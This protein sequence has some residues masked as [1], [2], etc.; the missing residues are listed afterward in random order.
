MKRLEDLLQSV[1]EIGAG[2]PSVDRTAASWIAAADGDSPICPRCGGFGFL[3]RDLPFGHPDFGRAVP[4]A[5][6]LKET[7]AEREHRLRRYSNLGALSRYTFENLAPRGHGASPAQQDRYERVVAAVRRFAEQPEGWL[8]LTGPSGSGKTHLAAALGNRVI[9]AGKSAL[10]MVVPDL[11]D[12]LR[13]SFAPNSEVPY[14]RL[15]DQVRNAG[16][17][18]LDDLGSQSATPWAV[19]KLYQIINHRF[20]L[21]LPTVLT[22]GTTIDE[23]D[24]RLRSRLAD[25]ALSNVFLLEMGPDEAADRDDPLTL[26]LLREMTFATFNYRATGPDLPDSVARKLQQ[27]F[28]IARNFASRPEGWLVLAGETGCGKTHLAAA[29][30]HQ[31]RE[32][33]HAH[34]FVAVPDLLDRLRG[35]GQGA[36]LRDE[37]FD[38]VRTCGFLVLD[39][40]GVHSD[41]AWAQEKLFQILNHRYNAKLPTVITVHPSDELP[42]ALRSRLYDDKVSLFVEIEAPDYR[43]PGRPRGVSNRRGRQQR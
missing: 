36:R 25:P 42:A 7:E 4:C 29:V 33:G 24:D 18:I 16:L 21:A 11:L 38:R 5:C 41:T 30:A 17:L 26:P 19:E 1:P 6:V 31:Q 23:L 10:F 13:T 22:L 14:D 3:R 28:T 27:A 34:M 2:A 8:V 39:D 43:N 40:L 15:F 9:A 20:N 35:G 37:Y 32:A 12:H